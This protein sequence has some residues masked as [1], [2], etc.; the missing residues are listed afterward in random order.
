MPRIPITDPEETRAYF[1]AHG[2][3]PEGKPMRIW[4]EP[5]VSAPARVCRE[6]IEQDMLRE[7]MEER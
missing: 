5:N 7:L 6:E 1:E 2:L 3:T 4:G